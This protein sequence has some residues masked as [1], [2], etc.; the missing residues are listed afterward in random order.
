[1]YVHFTRVLFVRIVLGAS[2]LGIVGV[3]PLMKRIS[4]WPQLVLGLA[5]NWGALIGWASVAGTCNWAAVLPLYV[6]G[7]SW[8]LIYDTIYAHQDKH[9]DVKLG[10]KSTALR[11]GDD[12]KLWLSGFAVMQVSGLAMAGA[13]ADMGTTFYGVS[14]LG[15]AAHLA[16]Q[17]STVDLNNSKDCMSKFLSNVYLGGLVAAGIGLD[18]LLTAPIV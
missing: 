8:T 10:L 11:F 16:W 7:I 12:T 9:D 15:T 17:I 13:V 1:M 4:Y 2:S 6:S 3:Y 14:V 5:F 18:K